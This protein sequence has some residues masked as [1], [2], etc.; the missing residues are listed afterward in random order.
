MSIAEDSACAERAVAHGQVIVAVGVGLGVGGAVV[1]VLRVDV[2]GEDGSGRHVYLVAEG[3]EVVVFAGGEGDEFFGPVFV[4]FGIV[5]PEVEVGVEAV[6]RGFALLMVDSVFVV[7]V[8]VASW[9][10]FGFVPLVVRAR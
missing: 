4:G 8:V 2:A 7:A 6:E 5:A 3:I 1:Y 9:F 10:L